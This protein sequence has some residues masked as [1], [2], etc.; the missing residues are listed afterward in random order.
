MD[1]PQGVTGEDYLEALAADVLGIAR[2]LVNTCR[3]SGK[4]REEFLDT[5]LQG[6]LDESWV[7]C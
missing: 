5:I 7:D 1:L 3:V 4:C 6:N 2:K